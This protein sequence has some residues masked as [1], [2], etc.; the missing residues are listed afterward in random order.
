MHTKLILLA[1]G[2]MA[3][4]ACGG[5]A[6]YQ[7]RGGM[8][9]PTSAEVADPTP[10]VQQAHVTS[11]PHRA[12][13]LLAQAC[14]LGHSVQAC[15]EGESRDPIAGRPLIMHGCALGSAD[16]CKI[17]VKSEMTHEHKTEIAA[18]E[19]VDHVLEM[20]CA[21]GVASA[22]VTRSDVDGVL[23]STTPTQTPAT[24]DQSPHAVQ[25]CVS[26][27]ETQRVTCSRQ[28]ELEGWDSCPPASECTDEARSCTTSCQ[29]NALLTCAVDLRGA[30]GP[31]T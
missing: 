10:L 12:F 28:C 13:K 25:V 30:C 18:R 6:R 26:T 15:I 2:S 11:D 21:Q 23:V 29:A 20:G 22:C 7:W 19:D 1:A 27:C 24:S 17:L 3:L 4:V 14:E 16:A 9:V 31:L 5:P 8:T